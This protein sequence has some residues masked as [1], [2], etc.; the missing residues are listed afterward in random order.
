MAFHARRCTSAAEIEKVVLPN[1]QWCV[2]IASMNETLTIRLGEELAHALLEE[3][4]QTGLPKGEIARQALKAR[5]G[6]NNR[7]TVMRRHFGAVRGPSDL[8]SNK[9]Y[10][11]TWGKRSA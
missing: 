6:G 10:R 5:L 9:I 2:T 8:S 11:R 7:L 3:S 1:C 4:R